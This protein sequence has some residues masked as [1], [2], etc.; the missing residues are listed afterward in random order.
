MADDA[1]LMARFLNGKRVTRRAAGNW[2]AVCPAHNDST[3]S[4]AIKVGKNGK[5]MYRCHAQCTFDE[6]RRAVE[7]LGRD[8]FTG[9]DLND[10]EPAK[11][12]EAKKAEVPANDPAALPYIPYSDPTWID[13]PDAFAT[14]GSRKTE[15]RHVYR[16]LDGNPLMTVT[17]TRSDQGSKV[18]LP[19]T[20]REENG[21][22][23]LKRAAS[24]APRLPYGAET[25]RRTGPVFIA[26]GEKKADVLRQI[27]EDRYCVISAYGGSPEN[28][29]LTPFTGREGVMVIDNDSP[30]LIQ[31]YRYNLLWPGRFAA[32]PTPFAKSESYD[33]AD[34]AEDQEVPM[35]LIANSMRRHAKIERRKTNYLK[36]TI[37]LIEAGRRMDIAVAA[38]RLAETLVASGRDYCRVIVP[39]SP[40]PDSPYAGPVG[41]FVPL[42]ANRSR[43]GAVTG[44]AWYREPTGG[45]VIDRP[46]S[47]EI[48]SLSTKQGLI[49]L[50]SKA[51]EERLAA[52][53]TLIDVSDLLLKHYAKEKQTRARAARRPTGRRRAHTS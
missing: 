11:S 12:P 15:R 27:L 42:I 41:E 47:E 18:F 37:M 32:M 51:A 16:D 39:P 36:R 20:P 35:S 4:L 49:D 22:L 52:F 40:A 17:M 29:D 2:M 13:R 43:E 10:R 14:L 6:I 9:R 46:A 24:P 44:F 21:Q 1:E 34:L 8:F 28:L 30:G 33:I 3:P 23:K 19:V 5:L 48:E 38:P 31:S 50:L 45:A 26:E 53:D 25:A 7:G